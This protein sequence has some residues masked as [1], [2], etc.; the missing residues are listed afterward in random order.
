V[1]LRKTPLHQFLHY[2][3]TPGRCQKCVTPKGQANK[4]ERIRYE[5]PSL[6]PYDTMTTSKKR[7]DEIDY[8]QELN[9]NHDRNDTGQGRR[10]IGNHITTNQDSG[11]A[12]GG[13]THDPS[14][15]SSSSL[16]AS[17]GPISM[18]SSLS[19][20]V[21][22][23]IVTSPIVSN[24]NTEMIDRCI[25]GILRS[26]PTL[27]G[28]KIVV[29]CDGIRNVIMDDDVDKMEKE[30]VVLVEEEEEEHIN[31]PQQQKQ[32]QP[33]TAT[34]RIYGKC[35]KDQWDRYQVFCQR[36]QSRSWLVVDIHTEW[37]GFALVLQSVLDNHVTTPIV[38]VLPHDYELMPST[39]MDV[40][41]P[42][43]LQEMMMTTKTTTATTTIQPTTDKGDTSSSSSNGKDCSVNNDNDG[44]DDGTINNSCCNQIV[45]IGLPNAHSSTF[46]ARHKQAL[47]GIP[48][49]RIRQ[50]RL[51][52]SSSSSSETPPKQ[53]QQ[54]GE[55]QEV[56]PPALEEEEYYV[57]DPL[58]MWKENPHFATV[59]AY[60]SIVYGKKKKWIAPTTATPT[61]TTTTTS[62]P[63]PTTPAITTFQNVV[64]TNTRQRFKN[65]NNNHTFKKG[66]FI[67]DTLGQ[68]MLN[69]IKVYGTHAF[70]YMYQLSLSKPCSY[71]LDG[72]RYIPINERLVRKYTVQ[73][74]DVVATKLSKEYIVENLN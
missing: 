56:V 20:I 63:T 42:T 28:C 57:L 52:W 35:T 14:S 69:D 71:H 55:L 29:A 13:S 5:L 18:S 58:A 33:T 31:G 39:L 1:D 49:R 40:H 16:A 4:E 66:Q 67:E 32:K 60:Q 6:F 3:L 30:K 61:N 10:N 12:D 46:K 34:K 2:T 54:E 37:K 74:F 24:P 65:K 36:L 19:S 70:Q 64:K 9:I 25:V 22:I 72:A 47:K 7:D 73:E 23:V 21:T 48:S 68:Q 26:F 62:T 44:V 53:Q 59:E 41:L 51:C 15:S 17:A 11:A 8:G 43:L 50:H 38:M 45:Y 27:M